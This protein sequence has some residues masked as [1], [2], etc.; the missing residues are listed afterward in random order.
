MAGY[1]VSL[2]DKIRRLYG[3]LPKRRWIWLFRLIFAVVEEEALG[4]E[5]GMVA[6]Y[7]YAAYWRR[8]PPNP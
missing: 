8:R 3:Y 4:V 6:Y 7:L 5:V 1:K 2:V